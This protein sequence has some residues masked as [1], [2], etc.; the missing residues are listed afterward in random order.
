[1]NEKIS[2][3]GFGD[4]VDKVKAG[5]CSLCGA[6]VKPEDFKDQASR[7]EFEISGLCQACQDKTFDGEEAMACP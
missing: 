4:E 1:M 3:M 5:N 2:D 6:V 7:A